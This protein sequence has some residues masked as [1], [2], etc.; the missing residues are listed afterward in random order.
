[1]VYITSLRLWIIW[2]GLGC[3]TG[4]HKTSI[5][6][7][8]FRNI[9]VP[10]WSILQYIMCTFNSKMHQSHRTTLNYISQSLRLVPSCLKIYHIVLIVMSELECIR[11]LRSQVKENRKPLPTPLIISIH[12]VLT[13]NINDWKYLFTIKGLPSFIIIN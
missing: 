7:R 10:Y 6:M 8:Q 9:Y 12:I 3:L 5:D 13:V 4:F 1:M 2:G 11:N